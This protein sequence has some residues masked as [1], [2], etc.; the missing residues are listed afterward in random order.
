MGR[1]AAEPR[2]ESRGQ[3]HCG[4]PHRDRPGS[5]PLALALLPRPWPHSRWGLSPRATAACP[6]WGLWGSLVRKAPSPPRA[7]L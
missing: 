7:C 3:P 4:R 1:P 6:V 2:R 5:P